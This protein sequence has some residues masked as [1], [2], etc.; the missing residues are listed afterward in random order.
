MKEANKEGLFKFK[1]CE[2]CRRKCLFN[3]VVAVKDVAEERRTLY[4]CNDS[5]KGDGED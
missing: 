3:R 1:G 5:N 4:A 2:G